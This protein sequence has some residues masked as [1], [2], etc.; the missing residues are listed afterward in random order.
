MR[1]ISKVLVLFIIFSMVA[2]YYS[3]ANSDLE[4]D[5][6]AISSSPSG[7][8][9][10]VA[11][12]EVKEDAKNLS[13]ELGLNESDADAALD[14][15]EDIDQGSTQKDGVDRDI[16][17]SLEEQQGPNPSVLDES[18]SNE[19]QQE[20]KTTDPQEIDAADSLEAGSDSYRT[21]TEKAKITS[22]QTSIPL[23]INTSTTSRLGHIRNSSVVI[24]VNIGDESTS[25]LA[26]S[27]YTNAV[28]YIKKLANVDGQIYYLLSTEPSSE[29]GVVGWVKESDLDTHAHTVIDHQEKSFN[30]KGAGSAYSKAW[31]GKKDFVYEDLSKYRGSEFQVHLTEKV[32][33]DIWYRGSLEGRT[34]WIHSSL[35]I[36]PFVTEG[37]VSA[38][39][40][41][42]HIRNGKVKIYGTINKES[43]AFTAGSIYTNAV[44][45]I[46]KQAIVKGTTY[47]L[48]ST[49]PSSE[50]GVVGWAKS[51]DLST[52][53]H[54]VVD[55]QSKTF[56][57]TGTG[58]A[59]SKAWGGKKDFVYEDLSKYKNH[60]FQVHL[61]E[62]VGNDI[63]Y[64]GTLDGETVWIHPNY[65]FK[66]EETNV[67]RL[68]HI[69]NGS[70][71]IY[72]NI[73]DSTT[74]FTAGS[75]Y[76]NAVYYIKKQVI[77][78]GMTYYLLSTQPSSE[79]GVVGWAKS[80]DLSTNS[81]TVVDQESK[82]FFIT[83]TG[84][85]YSK[86]WGGKKDFVYEDLSKYKNHQFQVH[87][88]EKVG[89]DIWYRGTLD[90]ETV[91]IHPNYL[92]KGEE[93]RVSRLG[94]IQNGGVVI[95]KNIGDSTTSFTAGST[96]TNAVYY[97]K[98]QVIVNGMTYYLLST[99]PSSE[100]GVVGW[101]KSTD[102]STFP[103]TVVDHES[104]SL[105][106]KG[107]GS[108]FGKAWGGKKDLVIEDLSPFKHE[109]F[110]VHLTEKVGESIWYRG[111][112]NG[113]TAWVHES[114]LIKPK[115]VVQLDS[116]YDLTLNRMLDIQMAVNPQTDK[117]YELWIR[118]DALEVRNGSGTVIGNGWNLR[119]GPG[120]IYRADGQVNNG[121]VLTLYK[122]IKGADNYTWYHVRNTSGW[123]SAES[124]DVKHYL[125]ATNFTGSLIDSLQFLKLSQSAYLNVKE[126]NE[127]ILAGK[128]ILAGRAQA[129]VDGGVKYG[130]NE[131]YLISHALL[132]TGN[133]SGSSLATGVEVGKD[134][135]GSLVLVSSTNRSS[136]KEIKIVYNMYGI[137]AKDSCPLECGASYAYE[138]GWFSPDA[139]IIGGAAFIGEGYVNKGQDTL[140]KMRWNPD[141]AAKNNYASH[142]YATDI[143]WAYKQTSRMY[144][145]YSL[146]DEYLLVLDVPRYK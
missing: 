120:T 3:Y 141:F 5:V 136:L 81:H 143:G 55:Q 67:S 62:K 32:G 48:L 126:V 117:K 11:P 89:N 20:N 96:Y 99:Q 49:Q 109:A 91:W 16:S 45:Y 108:A 60:Q 100:R 119:R 84:S 127:K 71:V 27:T 68:G 63:W 114:N 95:Y 73:G 92:F 105:Y 14:D 10:E 9:Q 66:G 50:K 26:G 18:E 22:I 21:A 125:D 83:G 86:A 88:T 33:N 77:V 38:T 23:D 4:L 103:H 37:K 34:V 43:T 59:Y 97:I 111:T 8:T 144:E 29:R 142:Q 76:T 52:N 75:T 12:T 54:T 80:T 79:R 132:E 78:N 122:S 90:G 146:L 102:L 7:E 69:R 6:D 118:E 104:K 64:R 47:Y 31:G 56:F 112:I 87:L 110:Q 85:A 134:N 36:T 74:S 57:I 145:L 121:A 58:S 140:Y 124:A 19:I 15:S 128:G 1:N 53:S 72:K 51:T 115:E 138:Q 13:S 106:F 129:F 40:K 133:G 107:T 130:V 61:T 123:V 44:Y 135:K 2:P 70:V 25:F 116:F 93:T 139:A 131:V 113:K 101:A 41:L 39:S 137:N 30:I 17:N 42:G 35:L 98:K 65:L 82:T 28:Y 94:H 24:Y 46:K